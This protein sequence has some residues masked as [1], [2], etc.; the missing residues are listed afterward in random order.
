MLCKEQRTNNSKQCVLSYEHMCSFLH[1]I[2]EGK[3]R[4]LLPFKWNQLRDLFCPVDE[5]GTTIF[6]RT[7][8]K[9]DKF[10]KGT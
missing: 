10:V 7:E 9:K 2:F 1:S 5:A 8:I 6:F 4:G 3:K